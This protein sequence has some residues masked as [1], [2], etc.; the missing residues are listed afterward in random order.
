MALDRDAANRLAMTSPARFSVGRRHWALFIGLGGA[1]VVAD[2]LSK[3]WIVATYE[4]GRPVDVIGAYVRITPIHNSGGLF[5]LFQ[6]Q[7][8]VFGVL[9]VAVIGLIVWYHGH[10]AATG[11]N[12]ASV[13]LGM[14]LGGAIGNFVDRLRLGY[15]VDFV[16]M[17]L[18]GWR[19]YTYNLAD[20]MIS[21]SILLLLAMAF[22]PRPDQRTEGT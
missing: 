17:G 9:S 20:S 13:A 2:Q 11:G 10:A 19:F 6:G 12:L 14:L 5:G 7:A 18:G 22:L 8:L 15:V 21:M 16:D 4:F 3:A 1:I